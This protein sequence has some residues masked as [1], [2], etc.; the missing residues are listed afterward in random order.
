MGM[1]LTGKTTIGK[2]LS[3]HLGICFYD[4]DEYVELKLGDSISNIINKEGEDKF[5]IIESNCLNDIVNIDDHILS[6]GG[7][8]VNSNNINMLLNYSTRVWL[9]SNL[10]T[11]VARFAKLKKN[12]RPLLDSNNLT[13]SLNN[14]YIN[15]RENYKKCSNHSITINN[16]S[17]NIIIN[18][19]TNLINERN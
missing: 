13:E 9:K 1:P 5:R 7:G 8:A 4:L 18:E 15:R 17:L 14:I 16:K 10:Q 11:L 3:K 19:L 2:A 6:L 12:Q